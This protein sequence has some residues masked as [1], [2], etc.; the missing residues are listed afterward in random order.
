M[1]E[2]GDAVEGSG[3]CARLEHRRELHRLAAGAVCIGVLR[4]DE[5]APVV[6][7]S[8]EQGG[9]G[10]HVILPLVAEVD[11]LPPRG[12]RVLVEESLVHVRARRG[13]R[14]HRNDETRQRGGDY[15]ND[16]AH[17]CS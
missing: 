8:T 16:P 12:V 4:A 14:R 13:G 15:D 3:C 17:G 7:G 6:V 5:E 2:S 9:H 10:F 1:P 11:A